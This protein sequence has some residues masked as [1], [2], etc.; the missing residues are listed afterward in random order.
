MTSQT[1][2]GVGGSA[3]VFDMLLAWKRRDALG[4]VRAVA[5]FCAIVFVASAY[6][7]GSVV[8]LVVPILAAFFSLW[9]SL[10]RVV[11]PSFQLAVH[12]S[13]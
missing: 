10:V 7:L 9:I 13:S 11:S 3:D 1:S 2:S 8:V 12:L 4:A 6:F 5:G